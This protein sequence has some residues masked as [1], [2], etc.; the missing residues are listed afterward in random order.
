MDCC[1]ILIIFIGLVNCNRKEW[2]MNKRN[3]WEQVVPADI[4]VLHLHRLD[5][6]P[7]H[8]QSSS[9]LLGGESQTSTSLRRI[10]LLTESLDL[11]PSCPSLH[12]SVDSRKHAGDVHQLGQRKS[13]MHRGTHAAA[14]SKSFII[15]VP[16]NAVDCSLIVFNN[17][18]H[19]CTSC[20]D[21]A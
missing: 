13:Y 19:L 16:T 18:V 8:A 11:A 14:S 20:A 4:P 9:S 2:V 15:S 5:I 17:I 7:D 21:F 3:V 6:C 12:T 10:F 1:C